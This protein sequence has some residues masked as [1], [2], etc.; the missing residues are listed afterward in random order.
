MGVDLT[1]CPDRYAEVGMQPDWFLAHTRIDTDRHYAFQDAIRDLLPDP[2]PPGTRFDWY[3][4]TGI[5]HRTDDPYGNPLTSLPAG[6]FGRIPE[7][8]LGDTSAW[9]RGIVLF[10]QTIAPSTRVVLWWH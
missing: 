7:A 9:N 8:I 3:S 10:L 2:L 6:R 4:D 1:L 5:E